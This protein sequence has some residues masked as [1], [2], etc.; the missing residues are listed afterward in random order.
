MRR[1]CGSCGEIGDNIRRICGEKKADL[2]I[3][4]WQT[5]FLQCLLRAINGSQRTLSAV[6]EKARFWERYARQPF[7]ARQVKVLNRLLDGFKGKLT[8]SKWAKLAKC[9]QD[10]AYRD[11]MSLVE[12]GALQK[13]PGG[14]R[15]TSYSVV[16]W[17]R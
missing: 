9:S 3:T 15:G 14:G 12:R 2:D 16:Q 6:L 5:W 8:S 11:I 4:R 1:L 13:G 17:D 7:N 10:T